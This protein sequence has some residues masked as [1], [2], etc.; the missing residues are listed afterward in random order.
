MLAEIFMLRIEALL[1]VAALSPSSA[2]D[3]R[4]LPLTV[5]PPPRERETANSPRRE[6]A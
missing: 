3:P 1:R 5:A 2:V 6:A 4:F